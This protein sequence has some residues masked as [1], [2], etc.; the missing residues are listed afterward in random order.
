MLDPN[1]LMPIV[2]Q[3]AYQ[4]SSKF[5]P[6]VDAED[7]VGTLLVFIYERRSSIESVMEDGLGWEAKISSTLRKVAFDHCNK[8]KAATEGYDMEDAYNYPV[9]AVKEMFVQ[10]VEDTLAPER[11]QEMRDA[12]SGVEAE[13]LRLLTYRLR[14]GLSFSDLAA[15]L[16]IGEAAAAKRFQ[17]A[18]KS[19]QKALGYADTSSESWA[20]TRA[21]RT[22]AAW[23]A[24]LSE[25]Y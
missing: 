10:Y 23:R 24:S 11:R 20:A 17:R 18:V 12:L 4:I 9:A 5:P 14:D 2:K 19:L 8:E 6:Y 13:A 3:V 21:V 16:D 22:N 1:K 25:L 7:V 15:T